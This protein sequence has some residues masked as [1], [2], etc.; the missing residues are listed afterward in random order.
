[1]GQYFKGGPP[2][3]RFLIFTAD[4]SADLAIPGEDYTFGTLLR[5]QALGDVQALRAGGR[6]VLRVHLREPSGLHAVAAR[7][8]SAIPAAG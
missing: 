1:T 7:L 8:Q 3:G 6:R 2:H 5:A 4:E